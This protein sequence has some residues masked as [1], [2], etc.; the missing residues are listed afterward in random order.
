MGT[1]RRT[2]SGQFRGYPR[3]VFLLKHQH[4]IFSQ[5]RNHHFAIIMH[6]PRSHCLEHSELVSKI[7]FRGFLRYKLRRR[8]LWGSF[9][10]DSKILAYYFV[11][12]G[13]KIVTR[14]T[15]HVMTEIPAAVE[16]L[17]KLRMF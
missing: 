9:R 10:Q 14:Y 16:L 7:P 6:I 17:P 1:Y 12:Q 15:G 4:A 3:L 8:K 2:V 5:V 13:N 11:T